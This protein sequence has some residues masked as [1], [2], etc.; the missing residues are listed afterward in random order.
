MELTLPEGELF[1]VQLTRDKV[2]QLE[3]S[4]GQ[5]VFV[6]PRVTRVFPMS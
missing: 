5:I 3:Q 4:E 1:S 2:D 6:C